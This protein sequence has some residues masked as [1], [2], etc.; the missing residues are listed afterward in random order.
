MQDS[1]ALERGWIDQ[2]IGDGAMG[3]VIAALPTGRPADYAERVVVAFTDDIPARISQ[4]SHDIDMTGGRRPVH[5]ISVVA[6]LAGVG[7]DA[8]LEQK[9]DRVQAT[10]LRGDMQHGVLVRLGAGVELVGMLIEQCL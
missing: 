8:A 9:L 7:V 10:V 6:L 2:K 3:D 1:L 4:S 5:G